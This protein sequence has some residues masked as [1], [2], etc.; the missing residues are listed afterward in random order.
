[1]PPD[2]P[3]RPRGGSASTPVCP[4]GA[5]GG[6]RARGRLDPLAPKPGWRRVRT[7]AARDPPGR[8]P[9]SPDPAAGAATGAAGAAGGAGRGCRE[10]HAPPSASPSAATGAGVGAGA[11]VAGAAGPGGSPRRPQQVPVRGGRPAPA[12]LGAQVSPRRLGALPGAPA[13]L[14]HPPPNRARAPRSRP[15][16]RLVGACSARAHPSRDHCSGPGSGS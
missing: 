7:R 8:S 9:G 3:R 12:A 4:G 2:A 16:R 1:M 10:A 6:Q 14:N 13:A 5:C 11:G 15:P